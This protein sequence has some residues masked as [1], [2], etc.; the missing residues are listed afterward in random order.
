MATQP[1]LE[2]ARYRLPRRSHYPPRHSKQQW[3]R[4]SPSPTSIPPPLCGPPLPLIQVLLP[5]LRVRLEPL[6]AFHGA[7]KGRSTTVLGAR[8][9]RRWGSSEESSDPETTTCLDAR[10]GRYA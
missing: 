2:T 10:L 6:D 9:A 5:H 7:C 8:A 3:Q 1:A 4:V